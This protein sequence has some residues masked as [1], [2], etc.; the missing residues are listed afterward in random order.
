MVVVKEEF[1]YTKSNSYTY[2][3]TKPA[4]VTS[5]DIIV[6]GAAGGGVGQC[7][8][9]AITATYNNLSSSSYAISIDI[10]GGG[11]THSD[12][13]GGVGGHGGGGNGGNGGFAYGFGFTNGVGG[14]GGGGRT[15][16]SFTDS[17]TRTI[18]SG[19]G[20]GSIIF[21]TLYTAQRFFTLDDP[22]YTPD[23]NRNATGG[24]GKNGT[25]FSADFNGGMGGMGGG[26]GAGLYDGENGIYTIN[27]Q[28][29]G[30][31]GT[32]A[33]SYHYVNPNIPVGGLSYIDMTA[34]NPVFVVSNGDFNFV[35]EIPNNYGINGNGGFVR[36]SYTEPPSLPCFLGSSKILTKNGYKL[37]EELRK[38][39]LVKTLLHGFQPIEM[40]GYST[41]HHHCLSERIENQLYVCASAQYPE[42]L[43]DLVLTGAHSLLV[44]QFTDDRQRK[45]TEKVL[46]KIYV[47]DRKYRLPAC[48]DARATVYNK[49]GTYTIYHLALQHE[50]YYMNYGIYANGLL[51]ETCSRRYL[52]EKSGMTL[53][54]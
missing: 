7:G 5:L 39:D 3:F 22:E 6:I 21:N 28:G 16:V 13:I 44:D 29:D 40:L 48:V 46:K 54:D 35:Y 24:N 17:S 10:G 15:S 30:A 51:V 19:G 41:I 25:T 42:V 20:A 49:P 33:G 14:D 52:K 36:I 23:D 38:G 18:I 37:I 27:G 4:G 45:E 26:G 1:Y 12:R 8:G 9:G 50:N 11:Q 43:E 47:T 31:P 32:G 2:T 34:V 53:I